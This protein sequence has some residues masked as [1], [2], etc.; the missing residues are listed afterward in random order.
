[1]A[2]LPL[3]IISGPFSPP[4][5]NATVVRQLP[6]GQSKVFY[7]L[8][9]NGNLSAHGSNFS[10]ASSPA[11]AVFAF[12]TK[13]KDQLVDCN[14]CQIMVV[15]QFLTRFY[16]SSSSIGITLNTVS[17]AVLKYNNTL[18]TRNSTVYGDV[19]SVNVGAVAET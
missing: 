15:W 12:L 18:I 6:Y 16:W 14:L 4:A 10:V 17:V 19:R 2:R 11:V 13:S 1:M 7:S 5:S 9:H 3:L 8:V